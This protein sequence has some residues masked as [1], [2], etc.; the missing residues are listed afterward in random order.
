VIGKVGGNAL[1][2]IGETDAYGP[3][4]AGEFVI[5]VR[6]HDF[7]REIGE[8]VGDRAPPPYVVGPGGEMHEDGGERVY[9]YAPGHFGGEV[10]VENYDSRRPAQPCRDG[11]LRFHGDIK[12]VRSAIGK[13]VSSEG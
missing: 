10:G 6:D 13:P 9:G 5:D 8:Y 1:D 11:R 4:A 12:T 3:G 7:V 2:E